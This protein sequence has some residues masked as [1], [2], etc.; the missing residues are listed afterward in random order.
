MRVILKFLLWTSGTVLAAAFLLVLIGPRIFNSIMTPDHEFGSKPL[1]ATPDYSQRS[2]WSAWPDVDSPAERLPDGITPTTDSDRRASAFF[3]HQTTYGGRDNWVQAINNE[4][5]RY[6]TDFGTTSRQASAFNACC[7]VYAPRYRQ[8]SMMAYEQK[9]ASQIFE[10]G[11]QDV[12]SAFLHFIETID[13]N[14]PFVLAGHSQGAF[15]LARLID[16]EVDGTPLINRLIA[17]YAIGAILPL[18]LVE[19]TYQDIELCAGPEHTGCFI[20]WDA[21]EADK[22]PTAGSDKEESVLWNG[23]DYSGFPP[24]P[25]ICVNPVTWRTD[26]EASKKQDHLGALENWSGF[27]EPEAS[28]GKLYAGSVTA[29]CGRAGE[30]NWLFVNGD[31]DKAIKSQGIWS[32]FERNLHGSDFSLFWQNIRENA[33]QRVDAFLSNR[34]SQNHSLPNIVLILADDLGYCDSEVYGCGTVPTPNITQLADDGVRFTAGY[35]TSP[36]CSP[37]RAGLLTGRYQHRFG[38]EFLVEGDPTANAGLPV[39]EITIAD[40]LG[41]AGYA[42]GM[43]GKWHL[44]IKSDHHPLNRGFD[45]FFGILNWGADYIDPT[46]ED[47]YSWTHPLA[48]PNGNNATVLI[49]SD[50]NVSRDKDFVKEDAYL[51][52]AFAREAVEFIEE[53]KRGPFFLYVPFTAIHGPLQVTSDY[54]DPLA[55]INDEARRIYAGMTSALDHGIGKIL[56]AIRIEGLE[57]NTIVVLLSD[58]GAGVANYTNNGPLRLGKHT[59]FEGGVRVPYIVKW[60]REIEAG[61]EYRQPVSALDVFPTLLTAAGQDMPADR[62]LDGVDLLPHLN[63]Q[64]NSSP[65]TALFWRQGPNWAVRQN[66]WKLIHAANQNWLYDLSHDP[67]E[68]INLAERNPEVIKKLTKAFDDWNADNVDPLWPPLGGKSLPSFAV[69]GV[70]ITWVL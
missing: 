11:Y 45:R 39:G 9:D 52:D 40:A 6:E 16:E 21:H 69:D 4:Q 47:V 22:A 8:T 56:R 17:A 33:K 70:A 67:A 5:T 44:G 60:P 2:S 48:K 38:H 15:H 34:K 37:S 31:R 18:A 53:K 54:Y 25:R 3:V 68:R 27:A 51:T 66:D 59:L 61:T 13:P 12:R 58:N 64:T 10:I 32:L 20:S 35:V 14:E 50:S 43:V 46:N 62:S 24:G 28:I 42:T 26:G 1:P 19:T 29:K 30:R 7:R 57:E 65:H 41:Q 36:V 49:H 63:R 23:K 55:H